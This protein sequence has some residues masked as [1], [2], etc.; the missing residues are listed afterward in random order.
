MTLCQSPL[1]L[2]AWL[3]VLGA[4]VA[5]P[6]IKLLHVVP[7]VI[8]AILA[9]GLADLSTRD[10]A[11]GT[12]S[13]LYSMPTVKPGYAW[14]K[15]GAATLLG[16]LFCVPP[17]IRIAFSSPGSALSLVIAAGFMGAL[18]TALG[19]LTRTPKAFMGVFLLFVYLVLNGAQVPA[20]DFAG[21]NGVATSGTRVGYLVATLVLAALAAAKHRWDTMREA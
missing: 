4:T 17:A 20:L 11:A 8:A 13:L 3:G 19:L 7:L 2:L 15:L 10:R 5:V 9:I 6:E 12:L 18:A 1:L 16:L 21:W 14:I